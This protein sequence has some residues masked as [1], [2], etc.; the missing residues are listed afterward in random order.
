M[1]PHH[2]ESKK[3]DKTPAQVAEEETNPP[4]KPA[5]KDDDAE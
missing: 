1:D 5:P 4:P 2:S 3:Q